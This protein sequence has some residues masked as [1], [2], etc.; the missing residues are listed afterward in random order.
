VHQWNFTI[1]KQWKGFIFDGTYLGN[2]GVG[3]SQIDYNQVNVNQG[4]F[5]QDFKSAYNTAFY[6]RTPARDSILPI[7]R[8]PGSVQLRL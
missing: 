7:T 8:H 3:C 6:R 2:H 1:E 5:L 4:T